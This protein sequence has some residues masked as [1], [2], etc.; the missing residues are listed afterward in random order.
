MTP[1]AGLGPSLPL[2]LAP[3]LPLRLAPSLPLRLSL[4]PLPLRLAPLP[5][6]SPLLTLERD[7]HAAEDEP[8]GQGGPSVAVILGLQYLVAG[9]PANQHSQFQDSI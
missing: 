5:S 2:R 6:R 1:T 3:S 4:P 8:P 7:Q 9:E